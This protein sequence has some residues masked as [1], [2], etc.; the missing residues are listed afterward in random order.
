LSVPIASREAESP[1]RALLIFDHWVFAPFRW[2]LRRWR[3]ANLHTIELDEAEAMFSRLID[4]AKQGRPFAIAIHGR[5]VIKVARM[6][7]EELDRL[8]KAE[9]EQRPRQH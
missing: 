3:H 4:E 1:R 5:P 8:P 9:E 6:E 7:R 2:L